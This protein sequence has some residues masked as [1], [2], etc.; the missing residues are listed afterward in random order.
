MLVFPKLTCNR[1]LAQPIPTM[2]STRSS[3]TDLAPR[4]VATADEAVVNGEAVVAT[5]AMVADVAVVVDRA[6]RE[7]RVV[8]EDLEVVAAT[9]LLKRASNAWATC[10]QKKPPFRFSKGDCTLCDDGVDRLVSLG[11]RPKDNRLVALHLGL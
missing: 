1:P 8:R 6:D 2:D 11:T 5:G 3:V 4:A 7:V 10:H 9:R